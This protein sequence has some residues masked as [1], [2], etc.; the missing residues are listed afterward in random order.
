MRQS[1]ETAH[2]CALA[3]GVAGRLDLRAKESHK[4]KATENEK[5]PG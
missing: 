2:L 3:V 5:V 4:K 1:A